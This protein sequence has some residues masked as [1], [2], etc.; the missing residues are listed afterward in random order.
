MGRD[1][2]LIFSKYV[3]Y[4]IIYSIIG[5]LM[6]V[7]LTIIEDK[8]FVNR[9][10]LIGPICPIYGWGVLLIVFLIDGNKSD[11][12]SVFL[13]SIMICSV[14]EYFT[15]YVMEK[16]FNARWWDY[17]NRKYNINGRICLETMIPFGVLGSAVVLYV[18]PFIVSTIDKLNNSFII[19]IGIVLFVL[20]VLDNLISFNV[21][22]KIK[23]EIVKYSLDNTEEIRKK[24]FTFLS[25]ST[26]L[27]KHIMN[28]FP[29]FIIKDKKSG[30]E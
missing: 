15:S 25:N 7:V 16:L 19:V 1:K 8:K 3:I 14:L 27:F 17:S 22:H 18:H 30:K 2:M 6:E 29:T 28:A 11:I 20:Y 21:M 10:F 24:V 26:Y 12:L 23:G 5:W 9:G 13:K 4:F